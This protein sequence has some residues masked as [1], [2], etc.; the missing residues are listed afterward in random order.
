M[1]DEIYTVLIADVMSSSG[2]K[3][4]RAQ[5]EKKLAAASEK[6]LKQKL[7]RFPYTVT[8]GDEFQTISTEL[9]SVP[10]L[11]LDL[12]AA[13]Q[14]LPLRIGVGI[15]KVAD[16]LQ[17]PV[18]RLTGPAFQF[19]RRGID[20]VKASLFKFDVL[21]AFASDNEPFNQTINLL[22]GLHDTLVSQITAKQWEAIHQFLDQPTLVQTAKRL[23]LDIST[24]SRNL[25]RGYYWQLSETAKVAGAFIERTFS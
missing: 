4:M 11:L 2:R 13:L 9:A 14:P 10:A 15:G 23:K 12:R 21:T 3:N 25:K 20:N 24:V 16:R 22:Y 18:N 8:A 6:H 7:I 5:L 17:P 19:A 1:A